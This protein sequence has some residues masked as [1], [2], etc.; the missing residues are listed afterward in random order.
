MDTDSEPLGEYA[1]A[2]A[3]ASMSPEEYEKLMNNPQLRQ[4]MYG[5]KHGIEDLKIERGDGPAQDVRNIVVPEGASE[6]EQMKVLRQAMAEDQAKKERAEKAKAAEAEKQRKERIKNSDPWCYVLSGAGSADINGTYARDET[7][8]SRNGS[9]VYQKGGLCFSREVIG[10]QGGFIVGQ[11][12]RAFYANQTADTVAPESGW[13]VQEHGTA[14]APTVTKVE[15][16]EAVEAAKARGN[17][18]FKAAAFVA[19]VEGYSEALR[20]AAA[21]ASAHGIDDDLL[22]KLHGNRA[23]AYLQLGRW[24]EA[25]ADAATA[26]EHDP[27]FVKAYVRRAKACYGL[28]RWADATQQLRDALEVEPGSKEV[29][30]LLEEYRI[31]ERVRAGTDQTL[32]EL[33][34]LCARLGVLVRRKGTAAEVVALLKQLPTMLQAIRAKQDPAAPQGVMQY[35]EA[36][37]HD[38]QVFLRLSTGNFALLAPLVRPTPKKPELL[39]EALETLA[40]A[41]RECTTNQV[42]FDRYVPQLVP[43]L[44]AHATLPFEVLRAAV[45][46]LGAMAARASARKLMHDPESAEGLMAVLSHP[47]SSQARPATAIIAAIDEMGDV[48]TLANLLGVGGACDTFWREC[49]SRLPDVQRPARS[50]VARAFGH[51]ACRKRLRLLERTKRLVNLLEAIT[52]EGRELERY[53]MTPLDDGGG[54]GG[55]DDFKRHDRGAIE[56]DGADDKGQEGDFVVRDATQLDAE[57][58]RVLLALLKGLALDCA[59]D[60][61]LVEAIH[62]LDGFACVLPLLCAA[63]PPLSGAA[64]RL[65]RVAMGQSDGVVERVVGS[66][67]PLWLLECRE[68]SPHADELDANVRTTLLPQ[69]ARDDAAQLLGYVANHGAIH[70]SLDIYEDDDVLHAAFGLLRG[71]P[72]DDAACAGCRCLE[73]LVKYAKGKRRGAVRAADVHDVLVPLWL[74]KEDAAKDGAGRVLRSILGDAAWMES[75]GGAY[76]EA[77]GKVELLHRIIHEMNSFDDLK[78]MRTSGATRDQL[79]PGGAPLATMLESEQRRGDLQPEAAAKQLVASLG[80]APAATV[81][82]VGAGTGLFA[83]EFAALLPRGRVFALEVRS[84]ALRALHA[85]ARARGGAAAN[86]TPMRMAPCV[87]PALPGGARADLVFMCDVL[88]FVEVARREEYMRSL[89]GVLAPGGKLVCVERRELETDAYLVDILDAGYVQQRAAQTIARRRVMLFE[90]DPA[91]SPPPTPAPPPPLLTEDTLDEEAEAAAA[92]VAQVEAAPKKA[93][94]AEAAVT[95]PAAAPPKATGEAPAVAKADGEAAAAGDDDDDD[96]CM[97]EENDEGAAEEEEDDD[98]MLEEND[99]QVVSKEVDDDDDE[100]CMLE[101]N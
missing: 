69:A 101:D 74:H 46:V 30:A 41:L 31:A 55:G 56:E 33:A 96:G 76:F 84:D 44:R 20:I 89:R 93:A 43:L 53:E 40:A 3:A 73:Y 18:A 71:N 51:A 59:A 42:A 97:L 29:V 92:A 36:P 95:A 52:K 32:T 48:N 39:R 94:A 5:M 62:R 9:R 16:V 13:S 75:G 27:C 11:A 34:A 72:S 58:A 14:P 10:G 88:E 7:D 19:A 49:H 82:D 78:A 22:G 63:R 23:E 68:G 81:V 8:A 80:L 91:A 35:V 70:A 90:A 17:G 100:G 83:F 21:C 47:D 24:E 26:L 25:E 85:T 79:R 2:A 1:K 64:L 4:I 12:P 65:L 50:L 77:Q 61:A 67:A 57:A 98:C 28:E 37:N 87:A 45:K 99:E 38:A 15:P 60:A 6:E 86:V 54:G 66:G